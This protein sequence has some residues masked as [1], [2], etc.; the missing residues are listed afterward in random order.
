MLP[1]LTRLYA[2]EILR[3]PRFLIIVLGGVLLVAGNALEGGSVYGTNT[4]PLTYMML[5]VASVAVVY[6]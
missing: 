2:I 6:P 4:Y 3:S 1:G 5:E